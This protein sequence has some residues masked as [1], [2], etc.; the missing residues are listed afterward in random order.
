MEST[1]TA[2]GVA[3]AAEGRFRQVIF[4]TNLRGVPHRL[5]FA[6]KGGK[7]CNYPG[8][9]PNSQLVP[10]QCISNRELQLLE[11]CLTYDNSQVLIALLPLLTETASQTEMAVTHRKQTTAHFLTETRIAHYRSAAHL[12]SRQSNPVF[13]SQRLL[14]IGLIGG[15]NL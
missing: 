10:R 1:V 6:T 7:L 15:G 14:S 4:D 9:R 3:A 12:S 11:P 13:R 5:R 8:L 2:G